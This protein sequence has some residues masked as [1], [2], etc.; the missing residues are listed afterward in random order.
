MITLKTYQVKVIG[1]RVNQYEAQQ[2]S[3]L[4]CS[5]G[6]RPVS[7][8]ESP[9]LT[10]VHSCAVTSRATAK[11]RR[12][13]RSGLRLSKGPVVIS[14]CAA[15]LAT[16]EQAKLAESITVISEAQD[17]A[18][19]LYNI[20]TK[21]GDT[22]NSWATSNQGSTAHG[23]HKEC[24]ITQSSTITKNISN[25]IKPLPNGIQAYQLEQVK[26]KIRSQSSIRYPKNG[27]EKAVLGPI[28]RFWGHERAFVKVQDGCDG[29]CSYCLIPQLRPSPSWRK[30]GQVVNEVKQLVENGY[31]EVVLTGVHLGAYGRRTVVPSY[32]DASQVV[33][34]A[35]LLGD[36]APIPG[37]ERVRLSSLEPAEVSEE[38]LEVMRANVNV[39]KHLHLPL[40]S[41]S[42]RILSRMN[43]QYTAGEFL[44]TVERARSRCGSMALSSDVIVGFPGETDEDFQATMDLAQQV[45]FGR[46]HVFE[47]SPRAGTAAAVMAGQVPK[48]IRQERSK[49]IRQLGEELARQQ[50]KGLIGQ[51]LWVLVQGQA[52]ADGLRSGLCEQ[53]FQ[54][55]FEGPEDL[56]G[57]MVS[58]LLEE[59]DQNGARGK[60]SAVEQEVT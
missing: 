31:R 28:K 37:L 48:R 36:V 50:Q 18:A 19:V 53:Y 30:S 43:R 10:I 3:E 55:A 59:V 41:G 2:I 54:V 1:C 49:Q 11:S 29:N 35:D 14:G 25:S 57:Q 56:S 32:C 8:G 46:M 27:T 9:D 13:V 16:K 42:D 24:M 20:V 58:V 7:K 47:F 33:S 5:L 44:E 40:Q 23:R 15:Q 38:L 51:Q 12:A 4:L 22:N 21:Q 17:I 45:G 52:G 6:L 39:A 60:L 34:L 26:T